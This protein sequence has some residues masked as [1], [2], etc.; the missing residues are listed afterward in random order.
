MHEALVHATLTLCVGLEEANDL[1]YRDNHISLLN[2][3]GPNAMYRMNYSLDMKLCKMI[4]KLVRK[5]LEMA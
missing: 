4:D 5:N 1:F 2:R 3:E